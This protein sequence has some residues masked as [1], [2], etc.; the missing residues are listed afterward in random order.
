M[1]IK[2]SHYTQCY[3]KQTHMQAFYNSEMKKYIGILPK[4][5]LKILLSTQKYC[6]FMETPDIKVKENNFNIDLCSQDLFHSIGKWDKEKNPVN[7]AEYIQQSWISYCI[8]KRLDL[9]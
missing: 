8:P 9:T 1:I 7:K 2:L 3:Q 6:C 5:S 4:K